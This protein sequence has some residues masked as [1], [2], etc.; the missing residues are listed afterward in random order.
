[1]RR[2]FP[3]AAGILPAFSRHRAKGPAST[4]RI[5]DPLPKFWKRAK[6]RKSAPSLLDAALKILEL[7]ERFPGGFRTLGA[8]PSDLG[9]ILKQLDAIL[10]SSDPLQDLQSRSGSLRMVLRKWRAALSSKEWT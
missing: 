1:M 6:R 5:S 7:A 2:A 10:S 3:G 4:P 9:A 8:D